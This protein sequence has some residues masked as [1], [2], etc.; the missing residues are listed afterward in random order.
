MIK[1]LLYTIYVKKPLT[2]KL[3]NKVTAN[4]PLPITITEYF[5]NHKQFFMVVNKKQILLGNC[6]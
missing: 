6:S 2:V 3:Q 4:S 1:S 5:Q